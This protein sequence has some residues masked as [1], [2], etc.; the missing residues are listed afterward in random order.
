MLC[1]AQSWG[2]S[3]PE[4]GR[5]FVEFLCDDEILV[6]RRF[7]AVKIEEGSVPDDADGNSA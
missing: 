4:P 7:D 5:Y 2:L 1:H 6:D 3:T